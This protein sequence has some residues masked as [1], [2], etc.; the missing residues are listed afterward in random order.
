ML[1]ERELKIRKA[2]AAVKSQRAR[3]RRE[4]KKRE[5]P[6][7]AVVGYTNAGV[8]SLS[9]L[10]WLCCRYNY[11]P[12]CLFFIAQKAKSF[13]VYVRQNYRRIKCHWI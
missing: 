13:S 8:P 12:D 9:H 5:F 4:R 10:I 1:K 6:I 3:L 11:M 2:L 7:I